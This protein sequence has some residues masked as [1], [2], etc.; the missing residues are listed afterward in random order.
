MHTSRGGA[1]NVA[2]HDTATSFSHPAGAPTSTACLHNSSK[3]LRSSG[4]GGAGNVYHSSSEWAI[5]SFDEELERQ[6]KRE[7]E[8]APIFH[9]GRGGAGNM[10][11][12]GEYSLTRK[13]SD[14]SSIGSNSTID[15]EDRTR[16]KTRRNLEKGWG[17][18]RGVSS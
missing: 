5:F 15:S 7:K 16:D 12:P 4:H 6:L 17:K 18:L 14:T 1:G 2:P 9:V 13:R 8:A 10:I 11:H 3:D